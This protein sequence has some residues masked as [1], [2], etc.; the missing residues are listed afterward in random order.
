MLLFQRAWAG[1]MVLAA[2]D[3]DPKKGAPAH[4]LTGSGEDE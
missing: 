4:M 3:R 1:K 2:L